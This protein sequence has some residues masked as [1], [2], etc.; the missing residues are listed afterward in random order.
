MFKSP[1]EEDINFQS[2]HAEHD[3]VNAPLDFLKTA[4]FLADKRLAVLWGADLLEEEEQGKLLKDLS[5]LPS[6]ACLVLESEQTNTRKNAFLSILSEKIATQAC[7]TPFEKDMPVWIENRARKKGLTLGRGV[8]M[9]LMNKIGGDLSNIDNA[10]EQMLLFVYPKNQ[11]TL[12]EA[13]KLVGGD[14]VE[15]VFRLADCLLDQKKKE[16]LS[17]LESLY[18]SGVRAPEIVASVSGQLERYKKAFSALN[19]GKSRADLADELRVPKMH[20]GPFFLRLDR[21]S[22][23]KIVRIQR[24]LLECD[25]SFKT[26]QAEEKFSVER[27]ILTI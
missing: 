2:F 6:S 16:A 22:K 9:F 1:S 13:Q 15:N 18:R 14:S 8:G 19:E 25:E 24:A 10:L 5:L 4:P 23:E 20:Q 7:H 11:A 21:M 26:G 17:I 12:E 3:E 27:F